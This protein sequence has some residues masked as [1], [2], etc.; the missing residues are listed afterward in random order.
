MTGAR[1]RLPGLAILAS[2]D[3]SNA[4]AI[5]EACRAGR[6]SAR[7]VVIASNRP[8]AGVLD[9]AR[10]AGI[11][12]LVVDHRDY[13]TRDAFD[14][15][16][17]AALAP[18]EPDLVILAGFMRILTPAF[19]AAFRGRL[20]NIHPSL[21]PKYPGLHTHARA[22]AAG[23]AEHGATVHFV[24]EELDGG[25]AALQA[26]VAITEHD[27]VGTLARRVREV[28]HSIYPLAIAWWASGRLR[29]TAGEVRLDDRRIPASGIRY[30]DGMA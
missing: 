20:L 29:L 10:Q 13:A 6:I 4:Q 2:G 19:I 28:E 1:D 14:R 12:A 27:T 26:V 5:V 22:L 24:T 16:M 30:A 7:V 8:E 3:G 18:H 15:A 17:L 23:D 11:A 25:P 9:R 21:L